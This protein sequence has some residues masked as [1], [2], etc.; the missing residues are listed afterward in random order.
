LIGD[1]YIFITGEAGLTGSTLIGILI[2]SNQ[3]LILATL[4]GENA[5]DTIKKHFNWDLVCNQT[6][7]VYEL[8]R[9]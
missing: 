7:A 2:E 1:K 6:L 5:R 9:K 8:I 4:V 3:V